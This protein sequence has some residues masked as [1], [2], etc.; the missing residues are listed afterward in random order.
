MLCPR[1]GTQNT[2]ARAACWSCFAQ[3]HTLASDAKAAKA[4]KAVRPA[5][6]KVK[7]AKPD[8]KKGKKGAPVE[9]IVP[10]PVIAAVPAVE[11]IPMAAA[12]ASEPAP[13]EIAAVPTEIAPVFEPISTQE[14]APLEAVP[15]PLDIPPITASVEPV[16]PDI[17]SEPAVAAPFDFGAEPEAG[18]SADDNMFIPGITFG[19]DTEPTAEEEESTPNNARV[20]DLD[21][22]VGDSSYIIPGLADT[23]DEDLP[24][25]GAMPDFGSAFD[26]DAET[27]GKKADVDEKK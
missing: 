4:A 12:V 15:A 14:P 20:M 7:P 6:L 17:S 24:E 9:D 1:C 25:F 10:E 26:L 23:E 16:S 8:R 3:L 22:P 19:M 5:D 11:A 21:A 18:P 13:V 27:P 2:D